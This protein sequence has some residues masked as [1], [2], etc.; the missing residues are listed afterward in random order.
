MS[1]KKKKKRQCVWIMEIGG[2]GRKDR[3]T[4]GPN[5]I[6]LPVSPIAYDTDVFVVERLTGNLSAVIDSYA[7]LN[8]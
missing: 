8:T 5:V 7:A 6:K 3:E 4:G 2:T 1:E